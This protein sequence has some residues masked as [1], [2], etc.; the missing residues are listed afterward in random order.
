MTNEGGAFDYDAELGRYHRRL[1]TA[2]AVGPDDRVL[3][4]GCGTGLT[5]REA[6]RAAVSGSAV[7]VDIFAQS[8]V[9]AR[10][11]SEEEG[12]ATFVSSRLT[13]RFIRFRPR[14][15]PLESAASGRCSSPILR[16]PSRILLGPCGQGRGWCN[17]YRPGPTASGVEHADS[18]GPR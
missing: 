10:R 9:T 14:A 11:L 3:D 13:R 4:I 2:M 15:S 16:P 5:T 7:G 17:W 6:G 12:W 18:R 8:L 1:V